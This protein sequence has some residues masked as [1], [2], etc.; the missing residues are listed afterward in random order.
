MHIKKYIKKYFPFS[1]DMYH[2]LLMTRNKLMNL[3]DKPIIVLLY[4]RVADLETD[5]QLLAVSPKNFD[6]Q[7]Q[8]LK[9]HYSVLHFEDD[10]R[11]IE[12]PSVIITFDDG[13]AD[14]YY[15]AVPILKKYGVPATIFVTTG[16]IG[17]SKEPWC[18]DVERAI[19]LND[20]LIGETIEID[21]GNVGKFS[22]NI[23]DKTSREK[24][25]YEIHNILLTVDAD[26]R[27]SIL[28]GLFKR[29]GGADIRDK[30]RYMNRQELETL[31]KSSLITIGGH[32][33]SHTRL[34]IQNYDEQL[35][36]IKDSKEYLENI[37][38]KK[39]NVFSFPF[40]GKADYTGDTLQ[41]L[42]YLKFKRSASNFSGQFHTWTNK[43]EIPRQIVR[44]WDIDDFKHNL[45]R[46][47]YI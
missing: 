30:H 19:L 27:E 14:N 26:V 7:M 12:T 29:Y 6:L 46:F 32:T 42:E 47:W 13:Y 8:Y 24:A 21:F 1:V 18:D 45:M 23:N 44:N 17:T 33:V 20:F 4:H 28:K 38:K 41:I 40:G 34:S 25:Y 10:W 9:E 3:Y 22:W 2:N 11:R 35:K 39:I 31:S 43:Y 37:L 15:N 5:P 16:R 36:E